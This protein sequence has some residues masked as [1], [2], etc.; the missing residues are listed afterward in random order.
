MKLSKAQLEYIKVECARMDARMKDLD[1]LEND[2]Y[3][4]VKLSAERNF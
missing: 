3:K 2:I 4:S 1:S